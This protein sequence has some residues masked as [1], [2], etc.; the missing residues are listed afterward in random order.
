MTPL[1][2]YPDP[3][4]VGFVEGVACTLA[5]LIGAAVLMFIVT[6]GWR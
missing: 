5:G 4:A 2:L 3:E 1:V 6:R